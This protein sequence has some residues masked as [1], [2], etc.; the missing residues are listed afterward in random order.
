MGQNF[1]E[2]LD[3]IDWKVGDEIVIAPTG[4]EYAEH[5]KRRI[6]KIENQGKTLYLDAPLKFFH[7]GSRDITRNTQ[8]GI[9]DMRGAVGL[10][11]RNILI[12]VKAKG[13]IFTIKF[14]FAT[15]K[16]L[17]FMGIQKLYT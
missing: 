10:L 2:V 1:I 15:I 7:Y 9:L 4:F 8:H 17:R 3:P 6:T 5:E 12:T 16:I 14:I 13:K 11:T